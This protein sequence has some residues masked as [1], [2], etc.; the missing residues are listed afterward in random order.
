MYCT[1]VAYFLGVLYQCKSKNVFKIETKS[2]IYRDNRKNSTLGRFTKNK[3]NAIRDEIKS[4][5][6][7]IKYKNDYSNINYI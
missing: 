6:K 1:D 4:K 5:L 7:N 2:Y 3:K